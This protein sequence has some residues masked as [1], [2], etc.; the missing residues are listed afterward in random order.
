MP[1]TFTNVGDF[2]L[3]VSLGAIQNTN[4]NAYLPFRQA[5]NNPN[6]A[7]SPVALRVQGGQFSFPTEPRT[8]RVRAGGNPQDTV[9]GSGAH[10]LLIAGIGENGELDSET[11]PLAGAAA[12][13]F[14]TKLFWRIFNAGVVGVGTFGGSN[15][16]RLVVE[17]SSLND[18]V[19]IDI[20]ASVSSLCSVSCPSNYKLRIQGF[21]IEVSSRKEVSFFVRS[22]SNFNV[23]GPP[24][25]PVKTFRVVENVPQGFVPSTLKNPIQ[26][27]PFDDFWVDVSTVSASASAA[28]LFSYKLIPNF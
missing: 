23:A 11:I 26:L 17:D 4:G 15:I 20:G 28:V 19:A 21:N 7:A 16:A 10:S 14:S 24:F 27:E 3:A 18:T 13:A 9:G 2:D 12:S 6:I 25:D 8:F 1:R 5:G 22:R